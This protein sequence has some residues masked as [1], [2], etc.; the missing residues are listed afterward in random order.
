MNNLQTNNYYSIFESPIGK[1]YLFQEDDYL[2]K[3]ELTNPD[4]SGY[5]FNQTPILTE[6]IK[7]LTEYFAKSRTE[8]DLPIKFEGTEF[9]TA[10]WNQL[11]QIPY[12]KTVSYQDVAIAINKPTACRAVGMTNNKNPLMIV[13]PCHRVIGK[14]G[15]LVGY[16]GGLKAKQIL[17]ELEKE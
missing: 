9:Q 5:E 14:N 2:V 3:I 10:V 13:I 11:R 15:S 6:A 17:L 16:G 4:I 1:L 8:F 12:G 7:Q